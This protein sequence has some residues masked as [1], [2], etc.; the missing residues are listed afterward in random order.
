MQRNLKKKVLREIRLR[1]HLYQEL[2]LLIK[3]QELKNQIEENQIYLKK[4][5]Q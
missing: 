1:M 5:E 3:K 2:K 4:R